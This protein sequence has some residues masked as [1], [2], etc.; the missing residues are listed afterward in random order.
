[1]DI[2]DNLASIVKD[3]ALIQAEVARRAGLTPVKLGAV[4]LKK[5]KLDANEL[6]RLCQVLSMSPDAVV[7]YGSQR[8]GKKTVTKQNNVSNLDTWKGE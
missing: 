1:M 3:R 5:R 2:R 6:L 7:S 4:L 8:E